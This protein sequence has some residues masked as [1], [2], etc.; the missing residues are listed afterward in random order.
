VNLLR[1][2]ARLVWVPFLALL[3]GPLVT[4]NASLVGV[5]DAAPDHPPAQIRFT[6][7]NP[8]L[9][10]ARYVL[11][12]QE[13]GSGHYSSDPGTAPL[14]QSQPW[15]TRPADR[16]IVISKATRDALFSEARQAK[17]FAG[18]CDDGGDRIA[19]QGKKTLEYEGTDG[20]GSCTYNWS[21]SKPIQL[22]TGKCESIA[23]TL[24]EGLKLQVLHEHARLSVDPELE[25][26]DRMARE[27]NALELGNI[28][29][30]LS[31]IADDD[32]ILQR[33]QRRA[34]GLLDMAKS[35]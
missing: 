24:E 10:P 11:I 18:S 28:A 27:G 3:G 32:A 14:E 22:I 30:V 15:P 8:K 2:L 23:L 21:T 7:E 9:Q 19:F 26:L 29:P 5:P 1:R 25:F 12:I 4:S 16:A 34:R 33:A 17:Y 6:Y 20:R 31:A 13:D 35:E